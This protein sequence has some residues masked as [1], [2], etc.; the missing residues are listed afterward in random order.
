MIRTKNNISK[1]NYSDLIRRMKTLKPCG[2]N[3]YIPSTLTIIKAVFC[4]YLFRMILSLN[5][6]YF[7]KQ[8]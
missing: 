4:I 3:I 2:K 5:S 6:D 7:L 1:P 8:H